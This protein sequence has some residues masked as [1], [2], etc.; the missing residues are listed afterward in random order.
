VV[1]PDSAKPQFAW[2]AEVTNGQLLE[3]K[4]A[5]FHR[6][7]SGPWSSRLPDRFRFIE[8]LIIAALQ[9]RSWAIN[10]RQRPIAL[11]TFEVGRA[12]ARKG[13]G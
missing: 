7:S 1:T 9:S 3:W 13:F 8:A 5:R 11:M 10:M 2:L 12:E 4:Q 6:D